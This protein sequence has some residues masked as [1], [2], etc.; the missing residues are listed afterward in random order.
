MTTEMG[1]SSVKKKRRGW[2]V[3]CIGII[4]ISVL[5]WLEINAFWANLSGNMEEGVV[6]YLTET[7]NQQQL[8][9]A[10][11]N[12]WQLKNLE[13]LDGKG[14]WFLVKKESEEEIH[15]YKTEDLTAQIFGMEFGG[16]S[17]NLTQHHKLIVQFNLLSLIIALLPAEIWIL[18]FIWEKMCETQQGYWQRMIE[19][20]WLSS[21][22]F[23]L[24]SLLLGAVQIPREFLP[25]NNILDIRF[26]MEEVKKFLNMSHRIWHHQKYYLN[27]KHLY[28]VGG[29]IY[30]LFIIGVWGGTIW[31]SIINYKGT[32]KRIK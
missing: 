16:E 26:Y 17:L 10:K 3:D 12:G 5:L 14:Q 27:L 1:V 23:L 9:D 20:G 32:A 13:D 25:E 29:K 4:A 2:E 21:V 6:L 28:E 22:F 19:C 15:F 31:L 7:V 11:Q 8:K 24:L 30:G 18:I